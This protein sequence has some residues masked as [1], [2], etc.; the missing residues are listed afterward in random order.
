MDRR[1][2]TSRSRLLKTAGVCAAGVGAA[3]LGLVPLPSVLGGVREPEDRYFP[4][5]ERE[6]GSGRGDPKALGVNGDRLRDAIPY[7]D[8]SDFNSNTVPGT[9]LSI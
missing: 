1:G 2:F 6:G 3:G 4:P 7:H 8:D 5:P 9:M